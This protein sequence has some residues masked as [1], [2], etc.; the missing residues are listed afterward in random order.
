MRRFPIHFSG[1]LSAFLLMGLLWGCKE[2]S[3]P[4]A[5][6]SLQQ[7]ADVYAEA[8]LI[9]AV[10]D[11]SA[12]APKIDSLLQANQV[13]REALANTV[14]QYRGDPR[15]WSL[16]LSLVEKKLENAT[17]MRISGRSR[18]DSLRK[19]SPLFRR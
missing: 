9:R 8:V 6:L 14:E 17:A 7:F 5:T 4:Q 10:M 19:Q 3:P 11:S 15:K 2:K 18:A 1:R 12:A 16:F 13:T